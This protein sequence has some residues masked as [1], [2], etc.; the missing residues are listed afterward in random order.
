MHII[1]ALGAILF[2]A[3]CGLAWPEASAADLVMLGL[4]ML[5]FGNQTL[6]VGKK[7]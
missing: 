1:V 7:S 2:M 5:I 4:L 3:L 6:D